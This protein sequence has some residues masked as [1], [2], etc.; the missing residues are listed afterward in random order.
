MSILS[1]VGLMSMHIPCGPVNCHFY[2]LLPVILYLESS[3]V[4]EFIVCPQYHDTVG[5]RICSSIYGRY[6]QVVCLK[7]TLTTTPYCTTLVRRWR[8]RKTCEAAA[9]SRQGRNVSY[10]CTSSTSSKIFRK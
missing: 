10:V 1:L 5:G 6:L 2:V 4:Q 8:E 3:P 7:Q 9:G